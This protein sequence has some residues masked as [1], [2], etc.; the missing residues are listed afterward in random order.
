LQI[1]ATLNPKAQTG[2]FVVV[3]RDPI[4]Q[5]EI[6]RSGSLEERL[7]TM[8]AAYDTACERTVRQALYMGGLDVPYRI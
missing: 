1:N 2:K 5:L 6:E 8:L 3:L 7:S 4:A